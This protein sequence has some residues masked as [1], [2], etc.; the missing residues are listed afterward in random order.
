MT[1]DHTESRFTRSNWKDGAIERRT[2]NRKLSPWLGI[3][4][5]APGS[6][7]VG[8]HDPIVSRGRRVCQSPALNRRF[9]TNGL[10][11]HRRLLPGCFDGVRAITPP[12]F[13]DNDEREEPRR[14]EIDSAK[15][16]EFLFDH[17]LS[18]WLKFVRRT[19]LST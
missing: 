13:R 2:S 4:P 9:C 17:P 1:H 8:V 18:F 19:P 10:T 5:S 11:H 3:L 7:L 15:V 16:R 6:F 14:V 12:R